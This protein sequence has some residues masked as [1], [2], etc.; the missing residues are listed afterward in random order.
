[1]FAVMVDDPKG[2]KTDAVTQLSPRRGERQSVTF[3]NFEG[4]AEVV[5][6]IR[7]ISPLSTL[8]AL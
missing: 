3:I 4:D 5:R 6:Q 1:M 7:I 2:H 8:W